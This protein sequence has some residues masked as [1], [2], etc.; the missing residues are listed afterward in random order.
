MSGKMSRKF[1][2]KRSCISHSFLEDKYIGIVL[3]ISVG[4][5]GKNSYRF[6]L[7][8]LRY[9]GGKYGAGYAVL[10]GTVTED[11]RVVLTFSLI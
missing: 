4:K 7:H 2:G 1:S 5:V 6:S 10:P 8:M 3:Y 11:N 9:F